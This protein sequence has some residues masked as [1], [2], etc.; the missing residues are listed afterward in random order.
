MIGM[1]SRNHRRILTA[2]SLLMLF[3]TYYV[4]ATM[5]WHSHIINGVTI[6]HSHIHGASHTSSSSDGGHPASEITLIAVCDVLQ[7]TDDLGESP[8]VALILV[9]L[10]VFLSAEPSAFAGVS[11]LRP[12]LRAPPVC[13]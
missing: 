4:N 12:S 2:A 11:L 6:V 10:C 3:V 7:M 13:L 9:L 5:F 8:V 1:R